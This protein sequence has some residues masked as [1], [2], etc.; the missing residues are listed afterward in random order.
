MHETEA[1]G[2]GCPMR[3]GGHRCTSPTCPGIDHGQGCTTCW[4]KHRK[5][6]R[7]SAHQRGYTALH[8][9]QTRQ[10]KERGD[11]CQCPGSYSWRSPCS[12][13]EG[14]CS[15]PA[16]LLDHIV[17][18]AD[19]HGDGTLELADLLSNKRPMCGSCHNVKTIPERERNK[20][21]WRKLL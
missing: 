14:A 4:K 19:H 15:K 3:G 16:T 21:W 5:R 8:A 7:V 11:M 2:G 12:A 17:S 9:E 13:C 18:L 10:M 1:A 20:G 6:E